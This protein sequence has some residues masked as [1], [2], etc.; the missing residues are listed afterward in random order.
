[1]ALILNIET[2]TSICSVAL[3]KNGIIQAILET[4]QPGSHAS[5]LTVMIEQLLKE[6]HLKP[7]DLDAIAV[8]KG[9]GSYTGLRIGTSVAKGICYGTGKPLIAISSLQAIASRVIDS[10]LLNNFSPEER[11]SVWICP[12]TDARRMEVYCAFYDAALTEKIPVS[13]EIIE[14]GS[15]RHILQKH[16]VIF[17]GNGSEKCRE[18]IDQ[19]RAVFASHIQASASGMA[20]LAEQSF[21]KGLFEDTAYFVPFYLKDF[22]AGKPKQNQEC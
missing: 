22:I 2:A 20:L 12:M 4:D 6:A 18:F 19:E 8:S 10:G 1:M 5:L 21:I 15:F 17:S 14:P 16:P 9:P 3:G 13:A 7:Q 11:P